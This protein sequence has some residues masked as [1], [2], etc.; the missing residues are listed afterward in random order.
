MRHIVMF[1]GGIGSFAAAVRVAARYGTTDMDLLFTDTMMEDEDLYRFIDEAAQYIGAPLVRISDGRDPWQVFRDER[2]LGNSRIDPCSRILKREIADKWL[3]DNCV[4]GETVVY[5]GIDWTEG[6][7]FDDGDGRGAKHR[8]ARNGWACEAPMTEAPFLTKRGMMA[9]LGDAGIDEPR[10]YRLGFQHNNCGGMCCKAG[11]GHFAHLLRTMP[12][13]YAYHE[14]MEQGIR[15]LLGKDVSMLSD[16]AGGDGKKPLTL[17][18][19]RERIRAGGQVDMF[20]IGGCN[21]MG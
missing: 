12:Q 3:A 7:R 5:L 17:K 19:L 13:R 20:D 10:L 1:S 6:H 18:A 4:R 16:R 8:Y 14:D 9:L 21:C 15:D 11:Q 2:M